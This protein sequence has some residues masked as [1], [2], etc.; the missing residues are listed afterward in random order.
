MIGYTRHRRKTNKANNTIQEI[1][2]MR[3]TDTTKYRVLTPVL[4]KGKQFIIKT[5]FGSSLSAAVG[6]M[7]HVLFMF[8]FVFFLGIVVSNTSGLYE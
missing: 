3:N 4:M 2:K 6:I 1:K 5:M 7:I 8:F